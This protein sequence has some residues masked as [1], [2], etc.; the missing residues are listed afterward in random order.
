[1][2]PFLRIHKKKI[3]PQKGAFY[4]G[5]WKLLLYE[6]MEAIRTK[7]KTYLVPMAGTD[8]SKCTAYLNQYEHQGTIYSLKLLQGA[9]IIKASTFCTT[10][11]FIGYPGQA[12]KEVKPK[13]GKGTTKDGFGKL[14]LPFPDASTTR[15][16]FFPE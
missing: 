11:F 5:R 14:L 13:P 9:L 12:S 7:N 3:V 6:F 4:I 15:L 8:E 1:M 16:Y 10:P 2:L